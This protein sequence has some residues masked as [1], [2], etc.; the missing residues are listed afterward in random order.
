MAVESPAAGTGRRVK[1]HGLVTP[2]FKRAAIIAAGVLAAFL[3][4]AAGAGLRLLMGPI[5]LGPFAGAIEDSLNRSFPG[6]T[7]RFD[8]VVLEWSGD[9]GEVNLAILGAKVFN[10]DNRIV[11]QAPKADLDLS[12]RP[13]LGGEFE[14]RRVAL[15]GP[16]LTMVRAPDGALTIGFGERGESTD[17]VGFA[18]RSLDTGY[19]RE[20]TAPALESLA[21]RDA[22]VAF[23]DEETGLFI[24]SPDA[25]F[26]ITSEA[27]VLNAT[28]AAD[29]EISGRRARVAGSLRLPEGA[30]PV[31]G[32]LSVA[33]LNLGAL[34]DNSPRFAD[35]AGVDLTTELAMNFEAEA[36]G[37]V[38]YADLSAGGSGR[39]AEGAFPFGPW[40]VTAV[41]G[42]ARYDGRAGRLLIEDAEIVS[43]RVALRIAGK[44]DVARDA[45]GEVSTIAGDISATE[46]ALD[47]PGT[48]MLPL[49]FERWSLRGGYDV[50]V[51][52]LTI[53]HLGIRGGALDAD[54]SL[55]VRFH[56]GMSPAIA[57]KGRAAA[58]QVR[59][60]LQFWPLQ[61]GDGARSW[62]DENISDGSVGPIDMDAD[63]Q[64]GA[65]DGEA[66]S[67]DAIKVAFP[68]NGVTATYIE[69]LTPLTGARGEAVLAGNSFRANISRADVG[70]LVLTQGSVDIPN[71]HIFG[72]PGRLAAH[73]EGE[74]PEILT[75]IDMQPLGY[76]SR[77]H[78]VPG[79]TAGTAK[80][81]FV[82][83]VPMLKD[84][85]VDALGIDVKA[86]AENV[87]LSIN[88]RIRLE[89]GTLALSVSNAGLEANG[90]AD[91]AGEPFQ[92]AWSENF[93]PGDGPSMRLKAVG[94]LGD[95]ARQKLGL[96][97]AEYVT[98]RIG[99]VLELEGRGG[100]IER[101]T[102]RSDLTEARIE[103]EL[104]RYVKPAGVVASGSATL[105]FA[106][107]AILVEGAQL[108]AVDLD[109]Q[110][111][112]VL[113]QLGRI[114][115]AELP[116]VRAGDY[117]DFALT[118]R[119]DATA[120]LD[121]AIS[122]R[123]LNAMGLIDSDE[124]KE[125]EATEPEA[126]STK[127]F[128]IALDL[129]EVHLNEDV[130]LA[131][132][133]LRAEG[134]GPV[135]AKLAF[136]GGGQ[137]T[138]HIDPDGP[139]RQRLNA[140]ANDA[141]LLLKGFLGMKSV[142]GGRLKLV[143][144]MET[145]EPPARASEAATATQIYKGTLTVRD[146]TVIDQPFLARLF[147]AGSLDGVASLLQGEGIAVERLE[148]PFTG[149]GDRIIIDEARA[150]GPAV[151]ITAQGVI[152]RKKDTVEI[153]GS[154]VPIY[155]LNSM[156]G[157]IPLV[158]DVLVSK[159]GEGIIGLTY[160]VR[161][162]MDEPQVLVN[163][164]SVLTPGI[165]RRIF[166]FG[167]PSETAQDKAPPEAAPQN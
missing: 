143:A 17:L 94:G 63:I 150:S 123:S 129:A 46:I 156:L 13:L 75:L 118:M 57:A 37:R 88:E 38:L 142:R 3:F 61:L 19:L 66:L 30:G 6:L 4:F 92:L 147:S 64:A 163:P 112:I 87:A 25:N 12:V 41:R 1:V 106:P 82:F 21:V 141:G 114:V 98:G 149:R 100:E 89:N 160:S 125:D 80:V 165:F 152:D 78:I 55:R 139:G 39:V 48:L 14:L 9:D 60:L 95:G 47:L 155:G 71:L 151:G 45:E 119:D 161:G 49:A 102:L 85:P 154:L 56:E 43:D 20:R 90:T 26:T 91:I 33:G 105:V 124:Q 115:E 135:V 127:P 2:V 40:Q 110:G 120:G 96:A 42:I 59:E 54:A 31:T 167:T 51:R 77:Y 128:R 148:V 158:G 32:S 68:L 79:E 35:L 34:A 157:A 8:E 153:G 50:P 67:D 145:A 86:A 162:D 5:S 130:T 146:F 134:T 99:A 122:G 74:F 83:D 140:S 53:D 131:P 109:L 107:E 164:L 18:R 29:V 133:T 144:T 103:S 27:G 52:T 72:S 84:L 62:I 22:R 136:D 70:R 104:V 138:A 28:L 73:V 159:E 23:H 16:Q 132:V 7:V 44:V 10:A 108:S 24:V 36:G 97:A 121:V 93:Q 111:R 116:V 166:E 58:M 81:D 117:N 76:P 69:G 65:L 15:V 11:A 101:G 137:V 126:V 113:D